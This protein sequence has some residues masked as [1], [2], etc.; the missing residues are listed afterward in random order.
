MVDKESSNVAIRSNFDMSYQDR[1]NQSYVGYHNSI[2]MWV[3][4]GTREESSHK[5]AMNTPA[6]PIVADIL[7]HAAAEGGATNLPGHV[8][9]NTIKDAGC[10]GEEMGLKAAV[11][12][13]KKKDDD[14]ILRMILRFESVDVTHMM[15]KLNSNSQ[16][17]PG[18]A[19]QE[20]T[21]V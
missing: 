12:E 6:D 1:G 9:A 8:K 18:R 19:V 21:R 20:K 13:A 7:H 17:G 11:D 3:I 14:W 15:F 2:K 16:E 10:L 4:R 5:M